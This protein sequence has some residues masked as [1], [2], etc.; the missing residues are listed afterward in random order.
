VIAAAA[1][2]LLL[3]MAAQRQVDQL[4]PLL[5]QL[6]VLVVLP[7]VTARCL[8]QYRLPELW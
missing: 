3:Q 4:S 2:Q 8:M 5:L 7:P 1:V 6:V